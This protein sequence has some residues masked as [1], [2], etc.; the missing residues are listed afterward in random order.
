[1]NAKIAEMWAHFK[2]VVDEKGNIAAASFDTA[3][4]IARSLRDDPRAWDL[5]SWR[6]HTVAKAK[7]RVGEEDSAQYLLIV[8]GVDLN[9]SNVVAFAQGDTWEGCFVELLYRRS[10]GEQKWKDDQPRNQT[11]TTSYVDA[12][13]GSSGQS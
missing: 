2:D 13:A 9:G 11:R 7:V 5:R 10:I 8:R 12:F 6:S 4:D 3:P 1:M